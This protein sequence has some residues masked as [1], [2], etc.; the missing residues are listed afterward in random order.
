MSKNWTIKPPPHTRTFDLPKPEKVSSL[1]IGDFV[2]LIFTN[3]E[4][5]DY[6]GQ[7][8]TER[9]WVEITDNRLP[10]RWRGTLASNPV[11]VTLKYG[12]EVFFDP[13]HVIAFMPKRDT[14]A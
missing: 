13:M 12:D 7:G 4:K 14:P 6:E 5:N 11:H 10:N 9:M 3:N 8:N 2:K 1:G